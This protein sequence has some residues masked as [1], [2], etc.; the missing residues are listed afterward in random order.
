MTAPSAIAA[1]ITT[2]V[3]PSPA[4][5]AAIASASAATTT[6]PPS[7]AATT[8]ASASPAAVGARGTGL[9]RTSRGCLRRLGGR[10]VDVGL[11]DH[12]LHAAQESPLFQE[13]SVGQLPPL[14]AVVLRGAVQC[15]FE[16]SSFETLR[17]RS[18]QDY[19]LSPSRSLNLFM[20]TCC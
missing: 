19:C 7:P 1:S 6:R 20:I 15:L 12:A 13:H 11:D 4:A 16:I 3:S 14:H 18:P 2:S 5:V 9:R 17:H 10:L 8:T